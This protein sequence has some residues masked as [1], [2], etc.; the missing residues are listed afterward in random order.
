M[1]LMPSDGLASPPN[2]EVGIV[3]MDYCCF[4]SSSSSLNFEFSGTEGSN[5]LRWPEI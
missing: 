1:V 4:S 3:L 2:K 5:K